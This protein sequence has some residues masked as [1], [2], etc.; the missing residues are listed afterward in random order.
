MTNIC[1]RLCLTHAYLLELITEHWPALVNIHFVHSQFLV[2]QFHYLLMGQDDC[3]TGMDSSQVC[4][5]TQG[6]EI[7]WAHQTPPVRLCVS[8]RMLRDTAQD[9]FVCCSWL[10]VLWPYLWEHN[11]APSLHH[12]QV[13]DHLD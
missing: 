4:R 11:D 9:G 6:A 7:L 2:K 10:E 8:F 12:N 5:D 3:P 1:T 13:V